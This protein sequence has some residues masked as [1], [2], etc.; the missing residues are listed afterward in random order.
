M[1]ILI[2][3]Y[4]FCAHTHT[5]VRVIQTDKDKQKLRDYAKITFAIVLHQVTKHAYLSVT[6]IL[7]Y[8]APLKEVFVKID[9]SILSCSRF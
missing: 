7:L 5:H 9:V 8:N 1:L 4:H 2:Q 3:T 6:G